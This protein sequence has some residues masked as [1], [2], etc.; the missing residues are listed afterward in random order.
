MDRLL[1]LT[2]FRPAEASQKHPPALSAMN[3][4]G[5]VSNRIGYL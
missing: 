5:S 3:K 1:E 2:C 4:L